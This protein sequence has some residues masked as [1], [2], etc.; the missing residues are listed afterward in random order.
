[1][2]IKQNWDHDK[3]TISYLF[4]IS[5][6]IKLF[7]Q[8]TLYTSTG[9]RIIGEI[10]SM[11]RNVLIFSTEYSDEDFHIEWNEVKGLTSSQMLLMYTANGSKY[12]GG[13]KL[14][15]GDS[16]SVRIITSTENISVPLKNIVEIAP[17]KQEFKDRIIINI[18]AGLSLT[19]AN[20]MRQSSAAGKIDYRGLKWTFNASF[21]NIGTV[22]DGTEKV[23]RSEGGI[24]FTRDVF[25]NTM[26]IGG[27]ESLKNSEQ[28]LDLRFIVKAGYGY[29]FIRTNH[30]YFQAGA[31]LAYSRE[32]YGGDS[33]VNGNSME[34]VGIAEFNAYDIGDF[35]FYSNVSAYPSLSDWGRWRVDLDCSLKYDL[36]LDF[37]IKFSYIHNFDSSPLIDVPNNDYV[38][39]TSIGWEWN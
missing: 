38:F 20:N 11:E 1:M 34:G 2:F 33:P 21:N 32:K 39:K 17:I 5:F 8:D 4:F 37:Y 9:D 27:I 14:E 3:K 16:S 26:V 7:A 12:E 28:M 10:E 13:L 30:L 24:G 36:P 18:D 15:L 25:G 6:F 31:G 19:K 29:Y 35:T 23:S 22:Q